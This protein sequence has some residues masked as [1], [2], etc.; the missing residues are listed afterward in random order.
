MTLGLAEP[1]TLPARILGC[2]RSED[3]SSA[4]IEFQT[5]P[6]AA[7]RLTLKRSQS[8]EIALS[9][10]QGHKEIV[11]GGME[12]EDWRLAFENGAVTG[13]GVI[14]DQ[15]MKASVEFSGTCPPR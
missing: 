2:Q 10:D 9:L 3:I 15:A 8:A 13:R 7:Q 6:G 5:N 14:V 4:T 12:G 11:H 1:L